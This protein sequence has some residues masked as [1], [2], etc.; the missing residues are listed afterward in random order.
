MRLSTH[1]PDPVPQREEKEQKMEPGEEMPWFRE[2]GD[3]ETGTNTSLS[4][5]P[6]DP[7]AGEEV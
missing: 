6:L 2:T 5:L 3:R 7:P 4:F 1:G